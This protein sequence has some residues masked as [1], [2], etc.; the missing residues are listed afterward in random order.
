MSQPVAVMSAIR[1]MLKPGGTLDRRRRANRGCVHGSRPARRSG[2]STRTA[3]CAACRPR[4]TTTRRPATG[5]VMRRSTF[6]RIRERGRV[7]WRV[8]PADRA[9]LPALLPA[10]PLAD[11]HAASGTGGV[12]Q[13]V[14]EVVGE[15]RPHEDP[16]SCSIALCRI[17]CARASIVCAHMPAVASARGCRSI[18]HPFD[19]SSFARGPA[20]SSATRFAET[21]T[22]RTMRPPSAASSSATMSRTAC[23]AVRGR[24]TRRD[25][26]TGRRAGP[27]PTPCSA[28]S[29]AGTAPGPRARRP[30]G[31]RPARGTGRARRSTSPPVR[32]PI[33][34]RSSS[35]W[36]SGLRARCVSRH[37]APP[38]GRRRRVA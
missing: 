29:A 15:R 31:G 6:E 33:A 13:P 14:D 20:S 2:S 35:R 10:R 3:C 19:R 1:N 36:A 23:R 4:W 27:P 38:P 26:A 8:G 18:E 9:R 32:T 24:A 7:R 34:A 28:W 21:S 5:T 12:D 22:T 30:P 25:R 16:R 37:G 17:T 11:R